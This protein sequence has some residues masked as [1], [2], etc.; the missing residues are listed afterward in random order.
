MNIFKHALKIA[1][2]TIF[3]MCMVLTYQLAAKGLHLAALWVFFM[4]MLIMVGLPES[5]RRRKCELTLMKKALIATVDK[6][7]SSDEL[8]KELAINQVLYAQM[9]KISVLQSEMIGDVNMVILKGLGSGDHADA[10]NKSFE[11]MQEASDKLDLLKQ[12]DVMNNE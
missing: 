6:I 1:N 4:S 8:V 3:S 11:I 9:S 10:V 2:F 12:T 7:T 5:L